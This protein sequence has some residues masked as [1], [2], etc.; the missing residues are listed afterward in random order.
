M[1]K[2]DALE[3]RQIQLA[4]LDDVDQFCREQHIRYSLCGG[5]LLGAVRHKGYIPWDDDI[6]LMMPRT[7]YDRFLQT[8][9]SACNQVIDLST[10][11]SCTEQFAK[12]SRKGTWMEDVILHRRLWG[13]N[14]DI[15][16][17][18]G[19]P[20]DYSSY[21]DSLCR[22]HDS[23]IVHCPVYKAARKNRT[24]WRIRYRLK[25]L[26]KGKREDILFLK[27]ELNMMVRN[28]RPEDSPLSTVI[29][30]DFKIFPFPTGLFYEMREMVFEGK[31]YKCISDTDTYLHAVYGDYMT[32]P[33]EEKRVSNHL[34][35]SYTEEKDE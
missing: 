8:Y 24:Y 20:S 23:I 13:V 32:L 7:D 29:F 27:R 22:I 34:Y 4:I 31:N 30:G 1:R 16:P 28:H 14:I 2:L 25:T 21:T 12:V 18:D 17:I 3:S 15:F 26:L 11:E 6:D 9:A 10:L 35:T 33:P 5:T 19:L